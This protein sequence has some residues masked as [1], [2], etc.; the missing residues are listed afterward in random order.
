M[1]RIFLYIAFIFSVA[2]FAQNEQLAQNYFERGEFEKAAMIYQDLDKAQARNPYFAQK[3]AECYQQLK[4]FDKAEKLL[5]DKI[6]LTRQPLLYVDL[7][8]N[9]QLQ[10]NQAKADAYYKKAIDAVAE[11]P[12]NV[13]TVANAFEKKVLVRQ[14]LTAYE[15]ASSVNKSMNFDYQM[16]LLQGQLGNVEQMIDRLLSFAFNNPQN[17]QM[18][19]NQL[20]RFMNEENTSEN[21]NT[22]LRKALLLQTQKSQDTFWNEFLSWYFVQRKEY[23]KAFIQQKAIYRRNPDSFMNVVN[24][25]RLA[26]EE[27]EDTTAKEIFDFVSQNTMEQDLLMDAEYYVLQIDIKQ[28]KDADL[29]L[30]KQR[31]DADMEKFGTTPYSLK[32]QILKADFEAFQLKDTKAAVATLNRALELQLNKFQQAQVKMKMSD[33]LL[34]EEKF[35]QAIIFY[36]QVEED[37]KNDAVGNEASFRVARA[38]YF[39]GDF[40]WAQKQLKVLKSSSSQLIANDAMELFLLI[41]DNT[42][43]DSTQTALK[44]FARADFKLYQNKKQE[45]LD[46]FKNL[47]ATDKTESIQDVTLLRLGRIYEGMGQYDLALQNYAEIIDKYKEGIYVDEALFYSAEI[48]NKKLN[49]PEKAKPLY[50]KMIF[51]HEDSIYFIEARKQYRILRGD[52]QSS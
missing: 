31:I 35:N 11:T 30:I 19:Q 6:E 20:S 12:G 14:A 32:L 40:E 52:A 41:S 36:A 8:Y 26:A 48:Y 5:L 25:G 51:E 17:L 47:R 27:N 45:A 43:E 9:Y 24:L 23:S 2:A 4:Q 29:P 1:K 37:L 42:V 50:E 13:F 38:S 15:T 3:L 46:E 39:K 22:Q 16:A 49:Q 10:Q 44:K 34:L 21:F 28:A 33:I 18:V 7:G